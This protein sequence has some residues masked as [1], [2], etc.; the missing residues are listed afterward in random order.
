MGKSGGGR[1][2]FQILRLVPEIPVFEGNFLLI[3]DGTK[4]GFR[5]LP[6]SSNIFVGVTPPHLARHVRASFDMDLSYVVEGHAS[7][8]PQT[9]CVD[10]KC[11]A[12][13]LIKLKY[14]VSASIMKCNIQ[15]ELL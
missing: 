15:F 11:V 12:L 7:A 6:E 5:T 3:A 13:T 14:D 4:I 10:V 2:N 8:C 1:S 9:V